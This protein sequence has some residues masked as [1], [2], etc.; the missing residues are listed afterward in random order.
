MLEDQNLPQSLLDS[1]LPSG[2][3]Q[4]ARVPGEVRHTPIAEIEVIDRGNNINQR[5]DIRRL[6]QSLG[7]KIHSDATAFHQPPSI[8]SPTDEDPSRQADRSP[9]RAM[10]MERPRPAPPA[11]QAAPA[12]PAPGVLVRFV[13]GY[14]TELEQDP[15]DFSYHH[16]IV[17]PQQR[18]IVLVFNT[19][20][21]NVKP[22]FPRSGNGGVLVGFPESASMGGTAYLVKGTIYRYPVGALDHYVMEVVDVF[23]INQPE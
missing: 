17:D 7:A 12:A 6:R 18:F 15:M 9:A 1:L 4:L 20:Y 19:A 21:R 16:V 14:G 8:G 3:A 22:W 5:M 2:N 11:A 23:D 13:V 10:G